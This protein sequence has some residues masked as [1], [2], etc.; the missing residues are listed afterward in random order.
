M[1][2]VQGE[3]ASAAIGENR[4]RWEREDQERRRVTMAAHDADDRRYLDGMGWVH[5][6]VVTTF[7]KHFEVFSKAALSSSA[8]RG[9]IS[10]DQAKAVARSVE[11][12]L[13]P[14]DG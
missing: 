8:D 13:E 5:R 6:L 9:L 3:R 4:R 2:R 11:I 14:R 1:K 12:R 10:S 7:R